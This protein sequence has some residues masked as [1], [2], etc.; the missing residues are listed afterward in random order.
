MITIVEIKITIGAS[1]VAEWLNSCALLWQPRVSLVQILGMDMARLI[2]P[3]WGASHIPQLEGPTTKIS[4]YVLGDLGR[5][6]RKK[7]KQKE[8]G[9]LLAQVPIFKKTITID[10]IN[11]RRIQVKKESLNLKIRLINYPKIKQ[12]KIKE[13]EDFF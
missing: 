7:K 13:I 3:R 6:S 9:K 5:K 10:G 4:N 11:R 1:P 8:I 2:R 12:E